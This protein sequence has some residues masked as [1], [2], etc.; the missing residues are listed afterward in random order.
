MRNT[1]WNRAYTLR[2]CIM[3]TKTSKMEREYAACFRFTWLPSC[4]C[5]TGDAQNPL[6][7]HSFSLIWPTS[8][9][10]LS[11]GAVFTWKIRKLTKKMPKSGHGTWPLASH[12]IPTLFCFLWERPNSTYLIFTLSLGLLT[13][14][15]CITYFFLVMLVSVLGKKVPS[16]N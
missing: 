16:L 13:S 14:S 12:F 6:W 10:K 9:V 11:L 2:E 15:V 3:C 1:Y 5:H 8:H 4:L 7:G